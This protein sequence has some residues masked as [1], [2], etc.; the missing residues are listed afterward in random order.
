MLGE[1]RFGF[2]GVQNVKMKLRTLLLKF[3]LHRDGISKDFYLKLLLLL[4]LDKF[5]RENLRG[6]QIN[7]FQKL[8]NEV[9]QWFQT[10]SPVELRPHKISIIFYFMIEASTI[11]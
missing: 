6:C 7:K 2:E 5:K 1:V 8:F 11:C 3:Y 4:N 10:I 9:K